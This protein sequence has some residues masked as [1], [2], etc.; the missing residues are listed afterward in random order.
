MS[1]DKINAMVIFEIL[2]KPKEHLVETLNDLIKKVGGESG[3]DVKEQ[4]IHEPKNVKDQKELFTTFAE[5]EIE[6]DE[7]FKIV[8]I[9][10]K[11]MPAHIEI[12]SPEKL[13]ISNHKL[14]EFLNEL[15]RRLHSYDEVA[16][17]LQAERM[18][19]EK[20]LKDAEEKEPKKD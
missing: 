8:V 5:V 2:G 6:V 4:I 13:Q 7:F 1:S 3:I 10:F 15:A 9:M 16:R 14:N 11:Y 20:R 19:L 18:V 17:I 12:M